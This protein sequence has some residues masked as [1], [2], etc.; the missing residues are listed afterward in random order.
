MVVKDEL[1]NMRQLSRIDE[2]MTIGVLKLMIIDLA[3]SFNISKPMTKGQ[4]EE[5][6]LFIL[7]TF[8]FYT[9]EDFQ[10]FFTLVKMSEFGQVYDRL[11]S[12][13][14]MDFLYKYDSKRTGEIVNAQETFKPSKQEQAEALSVLVEKG[15]VK[16]TSSDQPIKIGEFVRPKDRQKKAVDISHQIINNWSYSIEKMISE[17]GYDEITAQT[18]YNYFEKKKPLIEEKR[19]LFE[20]MF[21]T[22]EFLGTIAPLI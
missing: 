8:P 20:D 19:I 6:S 7:Q 3:N 15:V 1:L 10:L 9:L 22:S 14:V 12:S 17:Y 11:D 4:I 21:K 5:L 16:K 18:I 2:A 13:V